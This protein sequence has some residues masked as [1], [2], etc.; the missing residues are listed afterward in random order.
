MRDIVENRLKL[1]TAVKLRLLALSVRENGAAWTF[2]IGAYYAASSV[3]ELAF[4]AASALRLRK[5]L[6][7]MNAPAM[8][9]LIWENWNWADKGEEW[10]HSSEWKELIIRKVL[11]PNIRKGSVVVEIGPGAGRWTEELQSRATKLLGIDISEACIEK[12][13]QRF[14]G[15]DNVEF[16]VGNGSDLEGVPDSSADAVWSFDVFVHVNR[17]Q[18]GNYAKECARVL[19]P[20][21]VGIIHHGTDGGT[22]GGWRSDVTLGDANGFFESA[23]LEVTEQTSS[24]WENG[25]EFKAGLYNDVVTVFRKNH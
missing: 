4:A 23:G 24:W 12:C 25:R 3:A 1:G 16:W 22:T 18:F 6:P 17:P 11:R 7:G 5:G 15:C 2:L 9:R 14:V 20:G 21:G 8:N 19:K 13:R 10:T